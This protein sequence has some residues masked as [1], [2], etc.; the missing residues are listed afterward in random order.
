MIDVSENDWKTFVEQHRAAEKA[1]REWLKHN[2]T[3]SKAA[4]SA[5]LEILRIYESLHGSPFIKDAVTLRKEKEAQEA[6][7]RLRERWG[8]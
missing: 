8:R 5:C 3:T 4:I 7:V 2:P 1:E 6:W